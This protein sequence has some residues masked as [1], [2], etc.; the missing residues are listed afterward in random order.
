[1]ASTAGALWSPIWDAAALA[2]QVL[3]WLL[4]WLANFSWAT[5]TVAAAPLWCAVT[6]VAGGVLLA[7]RLPLQWRLLGAPLILPVLLWQ[8]LRPVVG[9]FEILGADIGQGNA[10]VV[11]TASHSLVYDT[12]PKF[13]RESDA[14][15]RVLV[16]LLRAM[17]D[18]K[19]TR[20]NSSHPSISR[21]PSSA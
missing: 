19:S 16:P 11:R 2:I 21:M 18:R 4:Q 15:N 3:S 12:G 6:G 14:G 13:S 5:L 20:L 8:P 10:L 9:Q 17:G 7:L 1:M